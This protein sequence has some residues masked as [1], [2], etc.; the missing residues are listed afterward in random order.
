MVPLSMAAHEKQLVADMLG[1]V[2]VQGLKLGVE[3]FP[4][5]EVLGARLVGVVAAVD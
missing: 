5:R 4:L 3:A 2:V 1:R